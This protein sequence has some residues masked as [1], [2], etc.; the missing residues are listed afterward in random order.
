MEMAVFLGCE[1]ATNGREKIHKTN[2]TIGRGEGVHTL[3]DSIREG[4]SIT[5]GGGFGKVP[6]IDKRE[7]YMAC[8][9]RKL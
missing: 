6:T 5:K 9:G 7:L 2:R 8:C 3:D 1:S 4:I